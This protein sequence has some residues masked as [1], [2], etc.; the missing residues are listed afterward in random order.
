[1]LVPLLLLNVLAP[2][3]LTAQERK[4]TITCHATDSN[5]DPLIGARVELQPSGQTATTD[6]FGQLQFPML[7]ARQVRTRGFLFRI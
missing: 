6:N 7:R 4:A 1:M 3:H 5:Q 2:L